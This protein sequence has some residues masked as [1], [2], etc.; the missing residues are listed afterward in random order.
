MAAGVS[1]KPKARPP[2]GLWK[3]SR[4]GAS[5]LSARPR[6]WNVG[7]NGGRGIGGA[8]GRRRS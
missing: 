3:V 4:Y 6:V 1:R 7:A 2:G 8:A 5:I